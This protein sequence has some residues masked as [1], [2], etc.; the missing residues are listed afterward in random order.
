MKQLIPLMRILSDASKEDPFW[1][2]FTIGVV[3]LALIV[4]FIVLLLMNKRKSVRHSAEKEDPSY[5][6]NEQPDKDV[7]HP[8]RS[9]GK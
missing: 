7:K 2:Y 8:W 6:F 1:L 4:A 9:H 3:S 5:E